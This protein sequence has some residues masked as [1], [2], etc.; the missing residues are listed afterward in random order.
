LIVSRVNIDAGFARSSAQIPIRVRPQMAA[1]DNISGLS[2]LIGQQ[3]DQLWSIAMAVVLAE[4]AIVCSF[5]KEPTQSKS[6]K[7]S[8]AL[9]YFSIIAHAFSLF[10]GYLTKGALVEMM[11]TGGTSMNEFYEAAAISSLLQ[12]LFLVLGLGIF[13]VVFAMKRT[14][15]SKAILEHIK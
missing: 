10:F 6:W 9:I 13:V 15:V 5:F 8:E 2:T 14:E 1:S 4:I 12:F 7:W 3:T 11:R